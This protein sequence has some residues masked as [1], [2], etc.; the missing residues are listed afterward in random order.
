MKIITGDGMNIFYFT[1]I[2]VA[3]VLF[4]NSTFTKSRTARV[5]FVEI[6]FNDGSEQTTKKDDVVQDSNKITKMII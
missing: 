6:E 1:Q 2:E 3:Y 4:M 5:D